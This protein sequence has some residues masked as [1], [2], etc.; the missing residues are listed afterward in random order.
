MKILII[1]PTT[2]GI[3]GVSQ[4]VTGL[5]NFLKKS[6]H[7]VEFISSANSLTIPI[8]GLKNPSFAL[9]SFLK[10]KLKN[11]YDIVH[12]HNFPSALA[13]KNASG[14]KILTLHGIF[15]QQIDLLYGQTT[16]R[17]SSMYE[18]NA[19]RWAHAITAVSRETKEFYEKMGITVS[20]IPNAINIGELPK[21]KN[22]LYEKQ[23][24]FVGRLSAEK[25]I[26]E[27]LA[28]VPELRQDVHLIILGSGPEKDAVIK[29]AK[30]Y[31]NLHY[32]GYVPKEKAI[33]LIRGSDILI[34]PSLT[35]G[36][37][38]TILEAMAC[39]TPIIA[40]NIR[41]NKE[42]L[43]DNET[44]I[45]VQV[46]DTKKMVGAILDLLLDDVKST[47]LKSN[48]FKEIQKY[49]WSNI[50]PQYILLYESILQ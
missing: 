44:G 38:T 14:K 42:I 41:G 32:M 36:M 46:G 34:Q 9:S 7:D 5:S 29:T 39:K 22:R 33:P 15:S 13:M 6:G 47:K 20:Y 26:L 21:E 8:K 2:T 50:G 23:I 1:S 11:E 27:L 10:V 24:I 31:K 37:S 35:E 3:G 43:L 19:L 40:T 49:D 45:L 18:K 16:R 28:I 17:L 48:A 25:G 4:H 12:A 30:K